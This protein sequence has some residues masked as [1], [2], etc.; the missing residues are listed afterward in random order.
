MRRAL[1]SLLFAP[2]LVAAGPEAPGPEAVVQKQIEA[3]NAHDLEAFLAAFAED[4]EASDLPGGQGPP[5]GKARQRELYAER[6]RRNPDLRA[7]VL[8]RIVSGPF[9]VQRERIS[10]RVGKAP[11]EAL[12]VYQV[13]RGRIR[14]MWTLG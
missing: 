10:G 5:A 13:E 14:R 12:V 9:V 8:D 7:S 4:L 11:L 3:F 6:F 2:L 1:P